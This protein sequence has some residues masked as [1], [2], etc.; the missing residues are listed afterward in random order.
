MP[1]TLRLIKIAMIAAIALF[2]T[3]VAFDNI[4]S[5]AT[6]WAYVQHVMSMD[7]TFHEPAF[8]GRAITNPVIQRYAYCLIIAWETLTAITC[9]IGCIVLSLKIKTT[10]TQFNNAKPI[11][12]TGLF[13][14]FLLYMVGFIIIGGEWF[15]MWQSATW[16]GQPTAGLFISLIMFVM[17][18]VKDETHDINIKPHQPMNFE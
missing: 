18:F 8:A 1:L 2:F 11:A 16:N 9:W 10:N 6:N 12:F 4:I 3:I 5:F 13:F 17:I 14:G 15:N 7:T